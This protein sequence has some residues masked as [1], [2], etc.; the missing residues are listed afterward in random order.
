MFVNPRMIEFLAKIDIMFLLYEAKRL[1]ESY[2]YKL[3][4]PK[5]FKTINNQLFI[6]FF[7][8][9]LQRFFVYF[10]SKF[11]SCLHEVL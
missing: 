5:S 9:H 4:N 8:R 2:E 11:T 1:I 7:I 6:K 10:P 3:L